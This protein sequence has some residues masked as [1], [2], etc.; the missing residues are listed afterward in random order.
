MKKEKIINLIYYPFE[1]I[2]FSRTKKNFFLYSSPI[3]K[4]FFFFKKRKKKV[5]I[6]F[7]KFK[8]TRLNY[9]YY[10]ADL[11]EFFNSKYFLY[12]NTINLFTFNN[13]LFSLST[14]K[15]NFFTSSIFNTTFNSL[16]DFFFWKKRLLL[17]AQILQTQLWTSFQ[18]QLSGLQNHNIAK[19]LMFILVKNGKKLKARKLFFNFLLYFQKKYNLPGLI[20]F[21]HAILILEPKVWLK[22][23]KI[24][25]KIYEIPIYISS[26]RSK[27]IAI[28]WL[29]LA[30]KKKKTNLAEG[31]AT[32][33]LNVAF[34]KGLSISYWDALHST[35]LKNKALLRWT[36]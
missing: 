8:H 31:L 29:L 36:S 15:S 24:A 13:F 21:I 32:E 25:G 14:L 22:K 27:S 6:N 17:W 16:E 23:K 10:L 20:F 28:W 11:L 33:V 2:V 3:F 35:V 19:M 5:L 9:F 1:I 18:V 7:L 26:R 30:A 12:G 34:S 4:T